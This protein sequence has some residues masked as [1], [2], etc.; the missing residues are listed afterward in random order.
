MAK[1]TNRFRRFV[2]RPVAWA[3]ALSL[4][5][6]LGAVVFVRSELL[7]G[8]VRDLIVARVQDFAGRPVTIG[9][10]H[11][12]FLPLA[13]EAWDMT[14]AGPRAEDPPAMVIP[15]ARVELDWFGW[16]RPVI[17]IRTIQVDRPQIFYT[18]DAD[19][20]D[21]WPRFKFNRTPGAAPAQPRPRR[22]TVRVEHL[23]VEGGEFRLDD[24]RWPVEIDA[25]GAEGTLLGVGD[26]K[27]RGRASVDE[28]D[29]V[30]PRARA[31]KAR[32]EGGVE[33]E[34]GV[35]RLSEVAVDA[36]SL[37]LRGGGEVRWGAKR[38]VDLDLAALG[39]TEVLEAM[40][41]LEA[42]RP[43][44]RGPIELAGHFHW[45]PA[46]WGYEGRAKSARFEV[47][48]RTFEG[49]E[50]PF[51]GDRNAVRLDI[52]RAGHHGGVVGGFFA[53][54]L[55]DKAYPSE[56]ALE[57]RAAD[58]AGLFLDQ[59]I[60]LAAVSASADGTFGYR[61]TFKNAGAGEG[62]LQA[63]LAGQSV[64]RE[65]V[66]LSGDIAVRLSG[67]QVIV[68][69]ATL[70]TGTTEI[71]A[72][73]SYDIP[74]EKG[75][76]ALAADSSQL[77]DIVPLLPATEPGAS[78]PL[79]VP[80]GGRGRV[81]VDLGLSAAGP[82]A[83]IELAFAEPKTPG[84]SG[85]SARGRLRIDPRWVEDLDLEI[86]RPGAR[87]HIQGRV[88]L[89]ETAA[90]PLPGAMAMR[91]E[92][93]GWPLDDA[94]PWLPEDL[95][96]LPIDGRFDGAIL[97]SGDPEAPSGRAQ[98][99]LKSA[100]W[101]RATL[102]ALEFEVG[103]SP[104]SID[105]ET[106]RLV[107]PAGTV[108]SRGTI[109]LTVD[110]ARLD[111]TL[112]GALRLDQPPFGVASEGAGKLAG[113][114]G[115]TGTI[116][117]TTAR[118]SLTASADL[119]ELS[120]AGQRLG[121][122]GTGH[123][124]ARWSE[125]VAELHGEIPGLVS[126]AGGGPLAWRGDG[127]DERLVADWRLDVVIPQ[128]ETLVALGG[129]QT[130]EGFGGRLGG[131]LTVRGE[132]D[133]MALALE[134][135]DF[136][137]RYREHRLTAIEPIRVSTDGQ[138]LRIGSFYVGEAG[139]ANELF[140]TGTVG[141]AEASA[142]DL[143]LQGTMAADWLEPML[144][145]GDLAGS[146][147]ALAA[148]RGTLARPAVSGQAVLSDGRVLFADFP[149]VLEDVQVTLL[150]DPGQWIL[151]LAS[152]RMGGGTVRASG[153][154][155][156]AVPAAAGRAASETSYRFQVLA[157]DVTLRYPEGFWMRG[158]GELSLVS[159]PSGR[160]IRGFLELSQL[161]YVR[162]IDVSLA[163]LLRGFLGK[164]RVEVADADEFLSTTQLNVAL[165][166][167]GT[168]RVSNNLARLRGSADLT[169]RGS[170]ASPVL[171]GRLEIEPGG[172]L[173]YGE[174]DYTIER[175]RVSFVNPYR[176]EPLIDL[177][178]RTRINPYDVTL[179]AVGPPERLDLRFSSDPPIPDL[180]ILTLI[181]SGGSG[182]P[183]AST[184]PFATPNPAVN[185]GVGG[186][187]GQTGTFGAESFLAGQ[188]ANLV[189][190]RVNRLFRFDRF[191]VAPLQG[192]GDNISSVRVTVGKRL[193]RDV[194]V[195]YSVDPSSSRDQILSV[196]WRVA[197]NL[198]LVFT[199][200][201]AGSYAVDARWETVF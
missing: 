149:Q 190:Q 133:A 102:G 84:L 104:R 90:S 122:E 10:V 182:D 167:P 98:G 27:L 101:D 49:L 59:S 94:R 95:M 134:V 201:G 168:F 1:R 46:A 195:T 91:V 193:S 159:A 125:L 43:V 176:I 21:N 34:R 54:D 50:G 110:P 145:P 188:A 150:A 194:Y 70:R 143:R 141:L 174:N 172:T 4:L 164:Q 148:V 184:G 198:A 180:D 113:R 61:F 42:A 140:L 26:L 62:E 192:S 87:A 127:E 130:P 38:S 37:K 31:V 15:H 28:V 72:S 156:P 6:A 76:F 24:V 178:A 35:V 196:E 187:P 55:T 117:G 109:D 47:L 151:D 123:I 66:P 8:R 119:T 170:L 5:A 12:S 36:P 118:P 23:R 121:N 99:V 48:G 63:R 103:F 191:R 60:P 132:L 166:A 3:S 11:L 40:G 75:R 152:F 73:G 183:G 29:L 173:V 179:S 146:I 20:R 111:L 92:S 79:W 67:G 169:V 52:E 177:K 138:T 68:P 199:Q 136:E 80:T 86:E 158:G 51:K 64:G 88:P 200:N 108:A 144:P 18:F 107:M 171:F 19:G 78:P 53:V 128:L 189:G 181:A 44:I 17:E 163:Q 30:L 124:E 155:T 142:L 96:E 56:V 14:L 93:T 162:D 71:S 129:A 185:G 115:L 57:F 65:R 120:F 154:I 2:L 105:V 85:S 13:V 16:R 7:Q 81:T 139:T 147:D 165:Q 106:A 32:V 69:P 83:V 131:S 137:A 77:T 153:A 197:S 82:E 112:D 126:V 175:A 100:A 33:F 25:R 157:R 116:Q 74:A 89:R 160:Q 186:V 39:T 114:A 41:Y 58:A 9:R 135:G 97:L 161:A 45:E 22:F